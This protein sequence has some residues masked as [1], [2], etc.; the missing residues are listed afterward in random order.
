MELNLTYLYNNS[1]INYSDILNLILSVPTTH[2]LQS[3]PFPFL[4]FVLDFSGLKLD[5][6]MEVEN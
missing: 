1:T 5:T 6:V 3:F 4:Y 2:H